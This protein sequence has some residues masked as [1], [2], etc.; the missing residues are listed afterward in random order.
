MHLP[1]DAL[2]PGI[3][4]RWLNSSELYHDD[5]RIVLFGAPRIHDYERVEP[6]KNINQNAEV[7]PFTSYYEFSEARKAIMNISRLGRD[8][9][10]VITENLLKPMLLPHF[11]TEFFIMLPTNHL[12]KYTLTI[13]T[14]HLLGQKI[15]ISS[16]VEHM[17]QSLINSFTKDISYLDEYPSF[18]LQY[19]EVVKA[20][21]LVV[22]VVAVVW[23][24]LDY[25]MEVLVCEKWVRYIDSG[26]W[27]ESAG[28]D[29][30]KSKI[31]KGG[32]EIWS[33]IN[34]ISAFFKH[35]TKGVFPL[36]SLSHALAGMITIFFAITTIS[37]NPPVDVL[38]SLPSVSLYLKYE[39]V[40]GYELDHQVLFGEY[41]DGLHGVVDRM[42]FINRMI[43][44]TVV[45]GS[46]RVMQYCRF[47][48]G[49]GLCGRLVGRVC[50][51]LGDMIVGVLVIV[52]V[53]VLVLYNIFYEGLIFS[54]SNLYVD[55]DDVTVDYEY[56]DRAKTRLGFHGYREAIGGVMVRPLKESA[57]SS[58]LSTFAQSFE[59]Y[60][61]PVGDYFFSGKHIEDHIP[62][63]I[64]IFAFFILLFCLVITITITLF[65]NAYHTLQNED[66]SRSR[67]VSCIK[68][69]VRYIEL[70]VIFYR[71][72]IRNVQSCKR[73]L[74]RKVHKE[75]SNNPLIYL[76]KSF[77]ESIPPVEEL[78]NYSRTERDQLFQ[79][80]MSIWVRSKS[81]M[82]LLNRC[83]NPFTNQFI[84]PS[85]TLLKELDSPHD[86]HHLT[87]YFIEQKILTAN[88]TSLLPVTHSNEN[89]CNLT[90]I[91]FLLRDTIQSSTESNYLNHQFDHLQTNITSQI[92][93]LQ[94]QNSNFHK[95]LCEM[96]RY[97]KNLEQT[98]I[99][100]FNYTIE[101]EKRRQV[102]QYGQQIVDLQRSISTSREIREQSIERRQKIE[103][104]QPNYLKRNSRESIP[105]SSAPDISI[106][107][108]F[109]PRE[110]AA[111]SSQKPPPPDGSPA[112]RPV[113]AAL[114]VGHRTAPM[115][116]LFIKSIHLLL[117]PHNFFLFS[118]T[119]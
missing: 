1:I 119:I 71:G 68:L 57:R 105:T 61:N 62:L 87:N 29:D 82:R 55:G 46:L 83:V 112:T 91:L 4:K 95:M 44:V 73:R 98:T 79:H 100:N 7:S 51:R 86:F 96:Q 97:T 34:F 25:V 32:V 49:M 88:P 113:L 19:L 70:N 37:V 48:D 111:S 116:H 99:A 10:G 42:A 24:L 3:D 13:K 74:P 40:G 104:K 117:I 89:A 21:L 23:Q 6:H 26:T 93:N 109:T 22:F 72:K 47:H 54:R 64:I 76:Q 36:L 118:G 114:G 15:E 17:H 110:R 75:D 90:I 58:D 103:P 92:Q 18:E 2:L 27:P 5:K 67:S 50:E 85:S 52:L 35:G 80:W 16:K 8:G 102:E 60:D 108:P 28:G 33:V 11:S 84:P 77:L 107:K 14:T 81:A 53:L 43:Y 56:Y 31:R 69:L 41:L 20:I 115:A 30:W 9:A 38:N 65:W 59:T 45:L 106:Q 78:Q 66:V 63:A 94:Q 12:V 39:S 101:T